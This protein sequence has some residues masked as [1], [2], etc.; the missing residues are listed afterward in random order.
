M[1]HIG[2]PFV[3]NE[4]DFRPLLA[5]GSSRDRLRG[6]NESEIARAFHRGIA[7]GFRCAISTCVTCVRDSTRRALRRRFP[8]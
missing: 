8:E 6:R 2:F 3:D 1:M 4:L 5:K 7:E